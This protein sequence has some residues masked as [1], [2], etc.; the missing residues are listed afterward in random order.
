MI[1][2]HHAAKP[3]V[4]QACMAL[5]DPDASA[6]LKAIRETNLD[7]ILSKVPPT[8]I[9]P[10]TW[11]LGKPRSI[12][13]SYG[14]DVKPNDPGTVGHFSVSLEQRPRRGIPSAACRCR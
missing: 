13:L 9:E 1:G 6:W 7:T 11:A 10:V 4:W 14:G 5:A 8:G 2:K 3:W 12:Q